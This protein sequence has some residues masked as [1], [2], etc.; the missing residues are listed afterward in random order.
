MCLRQAL[1]GRACGAASRCGGVELG[2]GEGEGVGMRGDEMLA[3]IDGEDE[4]RMKMRD[5]G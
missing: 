5:D 2:E 3:R 1:G 4:A